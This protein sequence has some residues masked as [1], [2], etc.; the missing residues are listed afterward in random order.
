MQKMK[1]TALL[2]TVFLLVS[3][4]PVVSF[5]ENVI[6]EETVYYY[7]GFNGGEKGNGISYILGIPYTRTLETGEEVLTMKSTDK[8]IASRIGI[9]DYNE[10]TGKT[11]TFKNPNATPDN[12]VAELPEI[13]L[14]YKMKIQ[15]VSGNSYFSYRASGYEANIIFLGNASYTGNNRNVLWRQAMAKDNP[16]AVAAE[17]VGDFSQWHTFAVKYN[18]DANIR[19][20]YIDGVYYSTSTDTTSANA[21][22]WFSNGQITWTFQEYVNNSNETEYTDIDYVKVY[23]PAT[24]FDCTAYSDSYN[25]NELIL[26]FNSTVMNIDVYG[27]DAGGISAAAVELLDAEKQTYKVILEENLLPGT[28]YEVTVS[29]VSDVFGNILDEKIIP[30]TSRESEFYISDMAVTDGISEIE[31]VGS[32]NLY[33]TASVNNELTSEREGTF[34]VSLYDYEGFLLKDDIYTKDYK[35]TNDSVS[36][37]EEFTVDDACE[38]ISLTAWKNTKTPV[39][40][41]DY[42]YYGEVSGS[43]SLTYKIP[44][45]DKEPTV[46]AVIKEDYSGAY[47]TVN[48]NEEEYERLVGLL[49]SYNGETEYMATGKT[50]NGEIVFELPLHEE[51][52]GKYSIT[53]GFENGGVTDFT[54]G[55]DYYSPGF[56]ERQ[57]ETKINSAD[58]DE[59][60]VGEFVRVLGDYIGIDTSALSVLT[61]A[62]YPYARL[63]SLRDTVENKKFSDVEEFKEYFETAV[64][65]AYIYEDRDT[66][67]IIVEGDEFADEKLK[68]L[69]ENRISGDAKR[70]LSDKLEAVEYSV[71]ADM[72]EELLLHT[73]IGAVYKAAHYKEVYAVIQAYGND[74]GINLALYKSLKNSENVDRAIMGK[75]FS[76]LDA[77]ASAVNSAINSRKNKENAAQSSGSSGGRGGGGGGG[78]IS[79]GIK[80]SSENEKKEEIKEEVKPVSFADVS[81]KDWFFNDVVWAVKEGMFIGTSATTFTPGANLTWEQITIVLSRL[82]HNYDNKNGKEEIKRGDFAKLLYDFIG[83]KETY[84]DFDGWIKGV[85]VFIG[86]TNGDLMFDKSLTRAE[87]CTVLRRIK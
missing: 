14:E 53:V 84:G 65:M 21:N 18:N 44:V 83:D 59:D 74:M 75:E 15:H 36:I 80:Y 87:C 47:V 57:L 38:S 9:L 8:K 86:D 78:G 34:I 24:E 40:V 22:P 29:G 63:L 35:L 3:V 79:S 51:Q 72:A 61:D 49:V 71:P 85:K 25:L 39:P 45:Y 56:I 16:D 64:K 43:E 69:I 5:A 62:D 50:E 77:F 32:G 42:K 2:I 54:P 76:S 31:T 67:T 12:P 66:V 11:S 13:V 30:Y 55:L 7:D 48:T 37:N 70:Y 73:V 28:E 60:S 33:Y 23:T 52:I 4:M 58:A 81:E 41:A 19:D 26:D 17:E 82:G 46:E 20:L 10:V 1:F 27:I 68:D 6:A